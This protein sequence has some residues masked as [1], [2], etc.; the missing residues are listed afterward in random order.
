MAF[1]TTCFGQNNR[2]TGRN[3]KH[4]D[5]ELMYRSKSVNVKM[6][7]SYSLVRAGLRTVVEEVANKPLWKVRVPLTARDVKVFFKVCRL[8]GSSK[9][10]SS[11]CGFVREWD[12]EKE[13]WVE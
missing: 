10:G 4:G 11:N 6:N 5:A 9:Q 2:N 12:R 3:T 1:L 8:P 7:V 13:C